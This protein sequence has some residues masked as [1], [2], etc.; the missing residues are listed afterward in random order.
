MQ[1]ALDVVAAMLAGAI[2]AALLMAA[3]YW[4]GRNSAERQFRSSEN[5]RPGPPPELNRKPIPDPE[6][7]DV[8]NDAAFGESKGP[9][10]TMIGR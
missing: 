1:E 9:V 5:A 2:L 7:G 3:G 10:S 8:Y 6:T 4:A